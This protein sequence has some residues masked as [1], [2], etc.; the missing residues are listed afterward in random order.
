MTIKTLVIRVLFFVLISAVGA[1][2]IHGSGTS[3]NQHSNAVSASASSRQPDVRG[4]W[5]G[6]FISRNADIAPFTITVVI[7]ANSAG[8]LIGDASLVSAC[9]DN[10]GLQV[11][12]TGSN[13]VLAGSDARGDTVTFSG[14]IDNTGTLLTLD[15]IINGSASA[16]CEID[17]G[18]GT[19][20]KR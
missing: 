10:H 16:R 17:N 14:T 20:G 12:V 2:L 8:H 7:S 19:M 3:G 1:E 15:Y 4:T 5:S 13:I 6:T 11:T 18:T 9:L